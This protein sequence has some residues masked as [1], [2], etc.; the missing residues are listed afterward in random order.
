MYKQ[1]TVLSYHIEGLRE[2]ANDELGS[3]CIDEG[4]ERGWL[5]TPHPH[6]QTK[7]FILVTCLHIWDVYS[8]DFNFRI[9]KRVT[10]KPRVI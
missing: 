4:L 6:P 8:F 9:L 3:M 10:R 5:S 7:P 2:N 1:A